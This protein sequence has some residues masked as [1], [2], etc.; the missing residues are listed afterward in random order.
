MTLDPETWRVLSPLLDQALELDGADREAW[1]N[2]LAGDAAAL[3]PLLRDILSHQA[4]SGPADPLGQQ[5]HLMNLA[6]PALAEPAAFTAGT[7]VGPY[8]LLRALGAGGMGEVL[9]A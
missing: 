9:L 2:Q 5:H 3:V 8:R 4:A 7:E 1:L 6:T